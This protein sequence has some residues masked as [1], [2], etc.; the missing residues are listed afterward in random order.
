MPVTIWILQVE[1]SGA[2]SYSALEPLGEFCTKF[3]A[4][5]FSQISV[6]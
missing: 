5:H 1:D 6:I 3:G 2:R 4:E